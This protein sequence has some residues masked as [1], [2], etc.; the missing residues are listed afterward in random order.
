[1]HEVC[2]TPSNYFFDF[3]FNF[4]SA[5]LIFRQQILILK[6]RFWLLNSGTDHRSIIRFVIKSLKKILSILFFNRWFGLISAQ[7]QNF[8]QFRTL[9]L[10]PQK[11][12]AMIQLKFH[13][14]R[15]KSLNGNHSIYPFLLKKYLLLLFWHV[16]F[17]FISL[18]FSEL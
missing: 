16:Y 8:N 2:S 12:S 4:I 9:V 1:M 13:L 18:F 11:K 3:H 14:F 10:L 17:Y 7:L 5:L 6:M 15:I